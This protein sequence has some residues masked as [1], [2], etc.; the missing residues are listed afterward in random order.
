MKFEVLIHGGEYDNCC[1]LLLLCYPEDGGNT[2]FQNVGKYL[3]DYML[4]NEIGEMGWSCMGTHELHKD[5]RY[6]NLMEKK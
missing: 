3:S 4:L 2:F 6:E 5:L 1:L